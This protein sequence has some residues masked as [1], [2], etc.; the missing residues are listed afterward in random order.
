MSSNF[1]SL[2]SQ[3]NATQSRAGAARNTRPPN[4]EYFGGSNGSP[5]GYYMEQEC[6][7]PMPPPKRC[8][9]H[10]APFTSLDGRNL[11]RLV[12]AYGHSVPCHNY[13]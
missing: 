7:F 11:Q 8:Y 9:C 2:P 6:H 3:A 10:P 4:R 12:D 5:G 13:Y 1:N